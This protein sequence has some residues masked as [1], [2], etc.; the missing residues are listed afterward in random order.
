MKA[1]LVKESLNEM[2]ILDKGVYIDEEYMEDVMTSIIHGNMGFFGGVGEEGQVR[3]AF[4]QRILDDPELSRIFSGGLKR[5]VPAR[6][7]GKRLYK[8]MV[9]KGLADYGDVLENVNEDMTP[10]N[11]K[12]IK[13]LENAGIR[14]EQLG[15]KEG[16]YDA[17][18]K[19][20]DMI[21]ELESDIM[22][23]KWK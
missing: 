4:E 22:N 2:R 17:F 15:T 13:V 9:D 5:H 21:M 6:D 14:K 20:A 1:K 8:L 18:I 3:D 10:A 19:M 16:V 11:Q 7:M 12:I 23:L